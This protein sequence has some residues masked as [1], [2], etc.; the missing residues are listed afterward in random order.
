MDVCSPYHIPA[1]VLPQGIAGRSTQGAQVGEFAV[2]PEKGVV[3]LVPGPVYAADDLAGIQAGRG[4][5]RGGGKGGAGDLAVLIDH[6]GFR[7]VPA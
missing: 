3:G 6:P 5:R 1:R 4:I 2:L 7:I